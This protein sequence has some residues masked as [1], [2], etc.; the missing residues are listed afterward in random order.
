[1]T[2]ATIFIDRDLNRHI[3]ISITAH[4]LGFVAMQ[5]DVR[6]ARAL[7]NRLLHE[8]DHIEGKRARRPSVPHLEVSLLP[9]WEREKLAELEAKR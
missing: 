2:K 5:L 8:C 3:N 7:A 4:P 9:I 1:M 6:K